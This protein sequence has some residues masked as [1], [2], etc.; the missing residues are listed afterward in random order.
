M[1]VLV[2]LGPAANFNAPVFALTLAISSAATTAFLWRGPA[3]S[4][5]MVLGGAA[6]AHALTL[7]AVPDFVD[8]YFR[9]IWDGW[10]TFQTGT[11][12]RAVP[13]LF[14][15]NETAPIELRA[16]L[17][18]INNPEYATIYG[19]VLQLVFAAMIGIGLFGE[20]LE[21]NVAIGAGIVVCAGLFTLWRQRVKSTGSA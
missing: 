6:L 4:G 16:T 5:R 19:P 20:V 12:Y 7:Y 1:I 11:P 21:T 17:D 3:I 14:V 15:A 9:F 18:R 10:Q 8:D 2:Q 13:E